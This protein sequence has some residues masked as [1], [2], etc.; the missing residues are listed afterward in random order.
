[1]SEPVIFAST[2]TAP[3]FQIHHRG[4]HRLLT[5]G[6]VGPQTFIYP[7]QSVGTT[8]LVG[9]IATTSSLSCAPRLD[10]TPIMPEGFITHTG[11][12]P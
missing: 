12:R 7:A 1:M 2:I 10:P 5:A 4:P 8:Q 11:E 3:R 6:P 9:E